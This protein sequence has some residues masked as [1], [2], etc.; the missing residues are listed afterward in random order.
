MDIIKAYGNGANPQVFTL[1]G[2]VSPGRWRLMGNLI[3][4]GPKYVYQ[5]FGIFEVCGDLTIN[6]AAFPMMGKIGYHNTGI[7]NDYAKMVQ[8]E[9]DILITSPTSG[10]TFTF[11]PNSVVQSITTN[12]V[13]LVKLGD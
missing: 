10:I 4:G 7:N 2:V 13:Y 3:T 5:A 6:S 12:Y 9:P 11:Y 8:F 1:N